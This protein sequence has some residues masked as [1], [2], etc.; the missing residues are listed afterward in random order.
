MKEEEGIDARFERCVK[1][2]MFSYYWFYDTR[3]FY[4]SLVKRK[5]LHFSYCH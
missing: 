5:T 1:E 2:M 4:H 3:T